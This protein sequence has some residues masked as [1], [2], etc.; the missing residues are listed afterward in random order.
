MSEKEV[1][2]QEA[3]KVENTSVESTSA[4]E[5][6]NYGVTPF[7]TIIMIKG[8]KAFRFEMPI[9]THY[10]LCIEA[11]EEVLKVVK[12]MRD[13]GLKKEE[14]MEKAAKES[15]KAASEKKDEEKKS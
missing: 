11:C 14:E 8:K 5:T 9:G 12:N 1:E 4:E 7:L 3:P 13:E 6:F 10:D 15:E 2:K